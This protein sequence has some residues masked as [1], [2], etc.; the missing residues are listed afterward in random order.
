MI[1][2]GLLFFKTRPNIEL[3]SSMLISAKKIRMGEYTEWEFTYYNSHNGYF[4]EETFFSSSSEEE[5][6]MKLLMANKV[7]VYNHD[8]VS[9][10]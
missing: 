2:R 4:Y 5:R 7:A 8:L 6:L 3:S 1:E 9:P 10:Y